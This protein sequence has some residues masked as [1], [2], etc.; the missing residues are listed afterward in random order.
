MKKFVVLFTTNEEF[1]EQ[2]I[3]EAEKLPNVSD[4]QSLVRKYVKKVFNINYDF[5]VN[6]IIE[7]NDYIKNYLPTIG[8]I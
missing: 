4:V 1:Q 6:E 7:F 5:R 2:V 3:V 8:K